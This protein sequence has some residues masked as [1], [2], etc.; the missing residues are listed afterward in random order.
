MTFWKKGWSGEHRDLHPNQLLF[1]EAI[2]WSASNGYESCD[3]GGMD[4]R[5]AKAILSAGSLTEE[6]KRTR[7]FFN[8][9]FGGSPVF[10]PGLFVYLSHPV[11]RLAYK[12]LTSRR[13]AG[14]SRKFRR[15][16]RGL[17]RPMRSS[18]ETGRLEIGSPGAAKHGSQT[19]VTS[20][21]EWK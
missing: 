10:L 16:M 9:G 5:V 4:H 13:F 17:F 21:W 14:V 6:L 18:V 15:I 1:W 19:L 11:F 8:L 7:D 12:G 3:F 20:F 2:E